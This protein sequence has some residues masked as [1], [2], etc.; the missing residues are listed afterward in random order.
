MI[1]IYLQHESVAQYVVCSGSHGED[2]LAG[3]GLVDLFYQLAG[4][5][6]VI[7]HRE[8]KP[9]VQVALQGTLSSARLKGDCYIV[10]PV[11]RS[12]GDLVIPDIG[13]LLL[14]RLE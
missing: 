4:Q 5:G 3:D 10:K 6:L 11:T 7:S 13:Y 12:D 8:I 2:P 14:V 9:Q 1:S